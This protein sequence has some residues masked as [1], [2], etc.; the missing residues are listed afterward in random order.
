MKEKRRVN[1][2]VRR[3]EARSDLVS[4]Q[5]KKVAKRQ[6]EANGVRQS[7]GSVVMKYTT[8]AQDVVTFCQSRRETKSTKGIVLPL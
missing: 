1:A 6:L 2:K 5:E 8:V 7:L 3:R 4:G